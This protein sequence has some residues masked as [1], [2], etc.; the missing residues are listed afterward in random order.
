MEARQVERS[1]TSS[2]KV[3][4]YM[5]S[6]TADGGGLRDN[7]GKARYDLIPPEFMEALALHYAKGAEKY[8]D[9]NWERGM[10]WQWVFAS[11]LRH[12]WAWARGSNYD[13]GQQGNGSHHMIAVAWNAIALY[14]YACRKV[15]TDDRIKV[16]KVL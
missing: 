10:S 2:L 7:G 4:D 13:D 14:T 11:L 1:K 5:K 6:I 12:L 9:R 3:A 15:G 16:G 8:G